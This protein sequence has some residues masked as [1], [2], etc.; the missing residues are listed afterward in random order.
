LMRIL[1]AKNGGTFVGLH[2]PERRGSPFRVGQSEPATEAPT[3]PP[4]PALKA[5]APPRSS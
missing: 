4:S 2:D 1:C 5:P 3:P